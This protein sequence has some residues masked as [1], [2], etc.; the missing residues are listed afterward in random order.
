MLTD[1]E[2]IAKHGRVRVVPSHNR[3]GLPPTVWSAVL[4]VA[5]AVTCRAL[6]PAAAKRLHGVRLPGIMYR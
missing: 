3:P 1:V 4:F 2:Q 5:G 6:E